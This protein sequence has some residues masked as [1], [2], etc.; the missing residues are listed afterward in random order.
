MSVRKGFIYQI[1]VTKHMPHFAK[2]IVIV[3]YVGEKPGHVRSKVLEKL[4]GFI[5]D[6]VYYCLGRL[7][8]R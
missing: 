6:L 8:E 3:S 7:I 4:G 1:G 5:C 2:G